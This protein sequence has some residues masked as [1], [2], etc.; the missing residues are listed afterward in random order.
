MENTKQLMAINGNTRS[1]D[2]FWLLVLFVVIIWI[3]WLTQV[4]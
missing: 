3:K 4:H 1:F 2:M